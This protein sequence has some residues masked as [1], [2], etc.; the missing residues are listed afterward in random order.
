MLEKAS[1]HK[2]M[3][4]NINSQKKVTRDALSY[5]AEIKRDRSMFMTPQKTSIEQQSDMSIDAIDQDK[6]ETEMALLREAKLLDLLG[7]SEVKK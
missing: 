1:G 5:I 3:L 4:S 6:S 7:K 2:V